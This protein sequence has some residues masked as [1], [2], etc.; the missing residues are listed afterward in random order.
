MPSTLITQELAAYLVGRPASTIRRW[1]AE[2]RIQ[3]YGTGR[4]KVRYDVAELPPA[5][6]C[7]YT[8]EVI[9]PGEA[10]ARRERLR[11]AA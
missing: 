3:R 10:P 11:S 2:G 5:R 8:G 1:A 4:G 6:R 9:E 7:E